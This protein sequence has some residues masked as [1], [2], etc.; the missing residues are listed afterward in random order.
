MHVLAGDRTEG[1]AADW[2]LSTQRIPEQ[3]HSTGTAAF[4]GANQVNIP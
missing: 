2:L 3:V 4:Q 1:S